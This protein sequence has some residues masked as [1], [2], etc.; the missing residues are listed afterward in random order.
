M[1]AWPCEDRLSARRQ[2]SHCLWLSLQVIGSDALALLSTLVTNTGEPMTDKDQISQRRV[3]GHLLSPVAPMK[4]LV[5]A[6]L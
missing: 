3:S 2:E 5:F 6:S 1:G 4:E